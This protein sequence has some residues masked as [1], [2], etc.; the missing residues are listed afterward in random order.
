MVAPSCIMPVSIIILVSFN[1]FCS[2]VFENFII[3]HRDK[4]LQSEVCYTTIQYVHHK[5][6]PRV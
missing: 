6:L 1:R 2:A 3:I 5:V 4:Q